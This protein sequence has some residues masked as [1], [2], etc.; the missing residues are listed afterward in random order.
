MFISGLYFTNNDL[1]CKC[2]S[3]QWWNV[4]LVFAQNLIDE[5][6]FLQFHQMYTSTNVVVAI[7]LM[8]HN[9]WESIVHHSF[10]Q[11][12]Q[13][14][15]CIQSNRSFIDA[16]RWMEIDQTRFNDSLLW[17]IAF[18]IGF[19]ILKNIARSTANTPDENEITK[20]LHISLSVREF[21]MLAK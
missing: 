16:T 9:N 8:L 2:H 10:Q 15:F 1:L 20:T 12:I 11:A 14:P 5:G 7:D 19:E 13:L 18:P 6:V 21:F 4:E 3:T 17:Q